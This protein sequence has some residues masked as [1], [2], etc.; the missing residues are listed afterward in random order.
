[1][2]VDLISQG[3]LPGKL[4]MAI[5]EVLQLKCAVDDPKPVLRFYQWDPPCLT[6]GYFQDITKEVNMKGLKEEGFDLVRRSTGGKA[7][8]HDDELT[9]SVV[10]R[11]DQFHGTVLETY[12]KLSQALAAG[13]RLAGVPAELAALQ[14]GVSARDS[15]FKQAACFSAPSWFEILA[16]GKKITGS[17]QNRKNGVILQHGSIPF[18]FNPGKVVACLS[19]REGKQAMRMAEFLRK[20]AMGINEAA[21]KEISREDLEICIIQGFRQELGWE[22]EAREL[23]GWEME[24]AGKIEREKYGNESWN[25]KRGRLNNDLF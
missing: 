1:M 24:L 20:K 10:I 17:A 19:S 7:V 3:P 4:N 23:T 14:R 18:T 2:K 6:V 12:Y 22:F 21:G 13:L 9:Y 15:R 16:Y 11:E 25:I 5:D 8:L